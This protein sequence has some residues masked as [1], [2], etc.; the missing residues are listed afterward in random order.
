MLPRY[1]GILFIEPA[2]NVDCG[3]DCAVLGSGRIGNGFKYLRGLITDA[4]NGDVGLLQLNHYFGHEE[5][6]IGKTYAIRMRGMQLLGFIFQIIRKMSEQPVVVLSWKIS[7]IAE[8]HCRHWLRM[9]AMAPA[10][11]R[12]S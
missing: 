4:R 3:T 7:L 6:Q 5:K 8:M 11:S 10:A 2:L 9:F 12:H 1:R